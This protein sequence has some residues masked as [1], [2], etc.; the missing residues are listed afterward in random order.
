MSQSHI[1]GAVDLV[2]ACREAGLKTAV[3]SSADRVKVRSIGSCI[4]IT[5]LSNSQMPCLLHPFHKAAPQYGVK[6]PKLQASTAECSLQTPANAH[7]R[8]RAD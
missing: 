4:P 7:Q 1:A 6:G 2:R 3:A 5:L 8:F